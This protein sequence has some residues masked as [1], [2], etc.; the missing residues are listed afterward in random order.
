LVVRGSTLAHTRHYK[1][2]GKN[3][4]T[5]RLHLCQLLHRIWSQHT[6]YGIRPVSIAQASRISGIT[7]ADVALVLAHL[8]HRGRK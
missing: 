1:R 4:A 7:P 5:G 8:E 2:T 3:F 6:L